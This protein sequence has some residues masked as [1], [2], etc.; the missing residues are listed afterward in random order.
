MSG[1]PDAAQIATLVALGEKLKI[2]GNNKLK[3][4]DRQQAI[5]LYTQGIEAVRAAVSAGEEISDKNLEISTAKSLLSILLSNR[6]HVRMQTSSDFVGA[7]EDCRSAVSA[8]PGN[9]KAYWRAAKASLG[10]ELFKQAADFAESAFKLDPENLE[11]QSLL[12]ECKIKEE[13]RVLGNQRA[14]V[15]QRVRE[16]TQ[17][18]A[19]ESQ[20]RLKSILDQWGSI[21]Q[22]LTGLE[23][24][25]ARTER[26][27]AALKDLEEGNVYKSVG[28][29]F[30]KTNRK[31]VEENLVEISEKIRKFQIPEISLKKNQLEKRKIDAEAEW[32]E[33]VEFL[34]DM[35][36]KA[37]K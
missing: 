7:I 26:T 15:K 16:F 32:A 20:N 10:L 35:Q 19:Q 36:K 4:N 5:A 3:E 12:A 1:I 28:R 18:E 23:G 25:A 13:A 30:L 24:E 22:Q 31:C 27:F 29:A 37:S 8:D 2:A 14:A 34:N 33:V 17:D 21:N 6:A 11:I 9:F